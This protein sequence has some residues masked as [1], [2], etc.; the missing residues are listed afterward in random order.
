M[1]EDWLFRVACPSGVRISCRLACLLAAVL[2]A[3]LHLPLSHMQ[4]M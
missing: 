1:C 3:L 2:A 4:L